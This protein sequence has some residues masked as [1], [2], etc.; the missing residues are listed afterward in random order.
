M[1]IELTEQ[2]FLELAL[3]R[4]WSFTQIAEHLE[5][6]GLVVPA[7]LRKWWSAPLASAAAEQPET[8]DEVWL[9][10]L[11]SRDTGLPDCAVVAS[12]QTC[13]DELVE[14]FTKEAPFVFDIFAQERLSGR[15]QERLLY[16]TRSP[17]PNQVLEFGDLFGIFRLQNKM[18]Y[19]VELFSF[20]KRVGAVIEVATSVADALV[21]ALRVVPED[22]HLHCQ[23]L[24]MMT[25]GSEELVRH[26]HR[27]LSEEELLRIGGPF[28]LKSSLA[29]T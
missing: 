25:A 21:S 18:L 24:G 1:K 20:G 8:T 9:V 12:R 16:L 29:T 3:L 14:R 5:E 23:L 6:M 4:K 28:S 10:Q 13:V 17:N 15:A 2:D 19:L 27:R 22:S 11:R 7:P 26:R